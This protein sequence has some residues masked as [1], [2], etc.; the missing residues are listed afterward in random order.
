MNHKIH[1][2]AIEARSR[3]SMSPMTGGTGKGDSNVVMERSIT[4]ARQRKVAPFLG[5]ILLPSF[6]TAGRWAVP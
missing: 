3:E 5:L 6:S 4:A 2:E 1:A